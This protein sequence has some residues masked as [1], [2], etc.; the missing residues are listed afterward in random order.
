MEGDTSFSQTE[1]MKTHAVSHTH[2]ASHTYITQ[3]PVAHSHFIWIA[4]VLRWIFIR[5]N[6]ICST[7]LEDIL[8]YGSSLSYVIGFTFPDVKPSLSR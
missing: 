2:I 8:G 7:G 5:C 4:M 3:N 1:C 6:E